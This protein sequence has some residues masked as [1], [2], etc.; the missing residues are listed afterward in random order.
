MQDKHRCKFLDFK[1]DS[2]WEG[3]CVTIPAEDL[4]RLF[5]YAEESDFELRASCIALGHNKKTCGVK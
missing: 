2:E 3:D 4:D 1:G 5:R